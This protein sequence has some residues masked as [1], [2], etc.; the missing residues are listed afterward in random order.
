MIS[1]LL[2][3]GSCKSY[4]NSCRSDRREW[5]MSPIPSR[6]IGL[7]V[8]LPIL[9]PLRPS[10]M[11]P[12]N[13]LRGG[14]WYSLPRHCRVRNTTYGVMTPTSSGLR[15]VFP[16][17]R[18]TRV[19]L[20]TDPNVVRCGSWHA[21]PWGCRSAYR[22]HG[23]PD[24]ADRYIGLR[25]VLPVLQ[26]ARVPLMTDSNV[27][28]GCSWHYYPKLC[29]SAYR[30]RDHPDRAINFVG[31][32]VVLPA[33]QPTRAPLITD[34]NVVRGGSWSSIPRGCRSTF[35]GRS[36][37]DV[38]NLGSGLRVVLPKAAPEPLPP[39]PQV[40]SLVT[41]AI[42]NDGTISIQIPKQS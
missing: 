41:I 6:R 32:R 18:P 25:V 14:A 21:I 3:G 23:R 16:T 28:R 8:V 11:I 31:L 1:P 15:V 39:S 22:G 9:P 36:L 35:H 30:N 27:L 20:M 34:L 13:K 2:R 12:R 42:L 10:L 26:P 40:V 37:P 17:L 38:A 7:R 29:R 33:P 5:R 4:R 19:P 24:Y